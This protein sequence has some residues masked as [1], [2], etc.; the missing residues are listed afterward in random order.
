MKKGLSKFCSKIKQ[1]YIVCFILLFCCVGTVMAD[2]NAGKGAL[3]SMAND[4]KGY[5]PVIQNLIYGI[6]GVVSVIGAFSCY[7]KMQEGDNDV[8]KSIMLL[9]GSC[10]FL[11][12]AAMSLPLFF[13]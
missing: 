13:E 2:M 5:I 11:V 4:I 1:K 9:I 12:G 10:I 7:F 6:A 8:K 3:A